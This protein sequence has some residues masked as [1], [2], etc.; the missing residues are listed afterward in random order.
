MDERWNRSQPATAPVDGPGA[1]VAG[2][3]AALDD[4]RLGAWRAFLMA[5]AALIAALEADLQA[6]AGMP[7][8]EYDALVQ[9]ARAEGRRLRMSELADRLLIT[10]SGV[11]R[12]VDRLVADGLVERSMCTPDGRGAYAV[13]TR[14]GFARLR[15][16]LPIHLRHVEARFLAVVDPGDLPAV[17]RSMRAIAAATGRCT[18]L[19]DGSPARLL[20][21]DAG[22]AET[23]P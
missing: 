9:L 5:Q 16:A 1:S 20:A 17:E 21:D 7:L 15:A 4:P 14:A 12:L 13:L 22:L 23:E 8:A 2:T 10:R 19:L 18:S 3:A 11:T 6:D